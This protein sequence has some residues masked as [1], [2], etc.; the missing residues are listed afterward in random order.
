[1]SWNRFTPKTHSVIGACA[2]IV[3]QLWLIYLNRKL[4]EG[5]PTLSM[6]GLLPG[7]S[8]QTFACVIAGLL[9]HA[10]FAIPTPSKSDKVLECAALRSLLF[11]VAAAG[12]M[13]QLLYFV[14]RFSE[15]PDVSLS[16]SLRPWTRI[17]PAALFISGIPTW[18]VFLKL[19]T[20]GLDARR[21]RHRSH[22]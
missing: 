20:D 11:G 4:E 21:H 10:F 14:S 15:I 16:R 12:I 3:I 18:F 6:P 5:I 1:M 22:S 9:G 17:V 19:I 7:W 8:L 2:L 13:F